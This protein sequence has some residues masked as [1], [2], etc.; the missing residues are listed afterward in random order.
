MSRKARNGPLER[1]KASGTLSRADFL[2]LI[3]NVIT[4]NNMESNRRRDEKSL[5]TSI[6]WP[7]RHDGANNYV[8]YSRGF[9]SISAFFKKKYESKGPTNNY[10]MSNQTS[11][12]KLNPISITE[13]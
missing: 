12:N 7:S 11:F 2:N 5:R 13:G 10:P 8:N 6:I 9:T 3:I 1:P 4:E